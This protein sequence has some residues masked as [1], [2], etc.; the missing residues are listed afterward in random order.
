MRLKKALFTIV[1][2]VAALG[3]ASAAAQGD[4]PPAVPSAVTVN[5][6]LSAGTIFTNASG[7]NAV[8][9]LDS[10][11]GID[12]RVRA[13]VTNALVTLTKG[14][15][16]VRWGATVGAYDLPV[17]GMAGNP[18]IQKGANTNLFGAVPQWYVQYA[19][20]S[21]FTISAGQQFTLLGT[22]STF[23]YQN[24]NIQRGLLWN[25]EPVT[26]R[27]VRATLTVGR[28]TAAMEG[29]DGYYTW[30]HVA[31]EGMFGYNTSPNTSVSFAF[32]LPNTNT[33]GNITASIA[34]KREYNVMLTSTAGRWSLS[35]YMLYVDSPSSTALG[36]TND[37]HA[38]GGALLGSYTLNGAWSVG[39]RVEYVK[40]SSSTTDISPNAD[41]VGY[42]P[43][44]SA[45]SYTITPTYKL[46]KAFVRGEA[47]SVSVSNLMPG[48][49]FSSAGTRSTQFRTAV[50]A[51]VQF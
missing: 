24:G 29:N 19:L 38:F 11:S 4:D 3:C 13:N 51:G 27:G 1:G 50:E 33:P 6:V 41:L 35:P 30:S 31:I 44:S 28:W 45:R 7:V 26:S 20:S 46:G 14:T 39:A 49:G 10:P 34:N 12:Q 32:I 43:G 23:T 37:E 8:G 17:A 16:T 47:S 9:S 42:G 5:G 18:L 40:N 36:Y 25:M 21:N 22:E 15:G 48:I 2:V